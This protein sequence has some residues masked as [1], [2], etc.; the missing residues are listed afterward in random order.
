MNMSS[1]EIRVPLDEAVA[2]VRDLKE[3]VVSLDRLGSRQASG[4]ADEQTVGTCITCEHPG[5][6]FLAFY[7]CY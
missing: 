3:F 1:W 2:V 6:T 5:I 7:L 4:T